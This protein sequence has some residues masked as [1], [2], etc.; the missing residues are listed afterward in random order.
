MDQDMD[1]I[2]D[3]VEGAPNVDTDGDGMPD[4][5]DEDSDNDGFLDRVEA[6][7]TYPM[8]ERNMRAL[9]CG[10]TSDNCD[11]PQD[12]VANFRDLDSDNDGLTDAEE[13]RL[14]TDPCNADTDRDGAPDLVEAV[15]MSDPRAD[16][17]RPPANTLYVVLPYYPPGMTGPHEHREFTFATRIR[18]ADV[19]FLVDNSASMEPVIESLRRN[20]STML[21]PGIRREI[22][23]IRV[24]V[25]SFD[26]MPEP[27]NGYPGMPGDYTL[28]VRQS[29]TADMA[30][31]QR[32]LD[33]MRTISADTGGRF[34]GGDYPECQTEAAFE[35]IQGD[36]SRG[37][38]MD[39]AA[40]RSV[41][42]A[43]D[44]AGNGWV[45]R[46]DPV[47]D[48]GASPDE[49][50]FGWGCFQ[51]GRVPIIVLA[52]DAAWYDGCIPGSPA[53]ASR[54][55]HNCSELVMA[56]NRRGGFFI[57]I[58]V[59]I[60][61]D[62]LLNSLQV[63]AMTRTLDGM[64][65]PIAF[66]PG[67]NVDMITPQ[68]IEAITRIAGSSRQD[69]TT[70]T[71]PDPMAMG[72]AMGHT[73]AD[74]IKAVVPARG[75]PDMPAGYERR[76][77]TTFYNVN[78]STQVVFDADFYNDFQEGTSTAQLF[79]A[80]I[81]VLGRGGSVVDTRP[82]FIVVPARGAGIAPM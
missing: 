47:R 66:Q 44:P 72:I 80:T 73:T 74:F 70:R 27:E 68:I 50:R 28:W 75:I 58:D 33:T 77:R 37:H 76:D 48:C 26:S 56:M 5:R 8:Y 20:L 65:R 9:M 10:G 25:G 78:P 23:D 2:S 4:F 40:R 19:F 22:P 1:G 42:N 45:P 64:G 39:A 59:G 15:A 57:G 62:T 38:E 55:G 21:I 41:L 49:T 35:L 52:S 71:L 16:T 60:T 63:A 14:M 51:E 82:V 29:I 81:N 32:A 18:L 67:R 53:T 12:T 69:I 6:T 43:L 54:A 79:R 30:R 13:R 17:S 24:G 61:G 7:R 34:F 3:Q 31:A 11:A 36:G 46:V